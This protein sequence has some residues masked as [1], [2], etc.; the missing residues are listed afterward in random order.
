M[1]EPMQ[2]AATATF[3]VSFPSVYEHII[4]LAS[5]IMGEHRKD[6]KCLSYVSI[7]LEEL[8]YYEDYKGDDLRSR[9]RES[10]MEERGVVE[11]MADKTLPVAGLMSEIRTA[12][13]PEGQFYY[14]GL[15]PVNSEY[16]YVFIGDCDATSREFYEP[17]FD[18]IWQS[19]RYVSNTAEETPE[20]G[21]AAFS[22]HHTTTTA[23]KD[24]RGIGPFPMPA[25]GHEYW[26][27]GD[28]T[29]TLSGESQCNISGGD[30][31]VQIDAR[32]PDYMDQEQSDIISSYNDK[33]VYLRFYFR[34]IYH[35]GIPT[36]KFYFE[37]E[38]NNTNLTFVW[39]GGFQ[40]SQH[41]TADVILENGWLYINGRFNAYPVKLAVRLRIENFAWESYRFLSAG[42]V[43]TAAPDVVHH[44]RLSDPDPGILE[45]TIQPLTQLRVLSIDFRDSKQAADFK[46][47]PNAVKCLKE[48]RDLSLTGVSALD[49]LPE[50][51]GDL[52]KLETIRLSDS[53]VE[54]IHPA[55][56][57]L[58][59]LKKLYLGGNQLQ[60]VHPELSLSLESLVLT[61]N[62]LTSVPASMVRLQYLNIERNPLQHLPAG[63]ENIPK[64]DLELAK[65]MSL[66]DYSY[67]GADGQGTI[68]YDNSRF[69]AKYD[70]ELL[71][72]LEEQIS[73]AGLDRFKEGLINRT[74]GSVALETTAEDS[75]LEKGNHRFGGLPDLPPG[76]NYPSFMDAYGVERGLQFIAQI[77]CVA[78]AHLQDYL[79][80]TGILYFFVQDLQDQDEMGP[81]ILYYDGDITALQSAKELD[82]EPAFIYEDSG[83]YTPFQVKTGKYPDMPVMYDTRSL[84]PEL[85][86]MEDMYEETEQLKKGLKSRSV[87]PVHSVNSHVFKQHDT[88]EME[89]VNA[90]RGKPE[91]WMVLLRVSSDNKTGFQFWDAGEIYFVIHKSDLEKKDFSNVYCGLESS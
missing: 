5:S 55:I 27:I 11:V 68:P 26:Q 57:Q 71:Q 86:D 45:E 42:E 52:Q 64:L 24:N 47:V 81:R 29:F 60:S 10:C 51:L 82:I 33:K 4:T 44:L 66:L 80:R 61:N 88:P 62:K 49:H 31:Y 83:I 58:P 23:A 40:Y 22:E 43:S 84:Y 87:D 65:K 76:I 37:N 12:Q 1:T 89:A 39:K 59:A 6:D 91:E 50:W 15:V 20:E 70:P 18:Q 35:A 32:A 28:H 21:D 38:R 78:I 79:P 30:L 67:Y 41:L 73:A 46:K 7:S 14:F 34:G 48:L 36:G 63:L 2:S 74:R 77:N 56:W 75:Y 25:S 53:R 19:L 85:A 69:Y 9:F 17:L 16:G 54:S 72:L 90:K 3:S 8:N 13:S